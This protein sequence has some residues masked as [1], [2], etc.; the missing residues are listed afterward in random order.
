VSNLKE[1]FLEKKFCLLENKS[2]MQENFSKYIK[3]LSSFGPES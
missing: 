2:P 3:V 1:V